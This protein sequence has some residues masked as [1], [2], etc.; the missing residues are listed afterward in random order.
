MPA[1]ANIAAMKQE[2]RALPY[3][4]N[5]ADELIDSVLALADIVSFSPPARITT[6]FHPAQY[7]YLL[8]TGTV[9]I[10]KQLAG[11]NAQQFVGGVENKWFTVGWSGFGEPH[12]YGATAECFTAC[13]ALR[14]SR[15][16]LEQLFAQFPE[17]GRHFFAL[18]L[19]SSIDLLAQARKLLAETAGHAPIARASMRMEPPH[20]MDSGPDA[21]IP[22]LRQSQ[23]FEVFDESDLNFL[24]HRSSIQHYR[25][26]SEI[27]AQHG[28]ARGMYFL[29]RGSVALWFRTAGDEHAANGPGVFLRHLTE[30]GQIL[31]WPVV[32]SPQRDDVYGIADTDTLVGFVSREAFAA[33]SERRPGFGLTFARQLL[34]LMGDQLRTSRAQLLNRQ[35]DD[36][37][38]SVGSIVAQAGPA[39]GV[40][41][42]LL[43]LPHLLQDRLTRGDAFRLLDRTRHTGTPLEKNLAGMCRDLLYETR[44]EWE[45]SRRLK[46]AYA[47]VANSPRGGNAAT[48][49]ARG[50]RALL[51]AFAQA[52]YI[53]QGEENLPAEPGHIFIL[54]HLISHPSFALPNGFELALDT[55]F[56]SAMLLYPR[57]GDG[58][59]RVVRQS[60]PREYAHQDYYDRLGYVSVVTDESDA[61]DLPRDHFAAFLNNTGNHLLAGTNVVICPEGR[62]LW[63]D[64]SPG[65]FKS[66]AF[67]LAGSL[68]PEPLIVPIAVA[69]FDKPL[70][71]TALAAIVNK[72]F[73]ISEHVNVRDQDALRNFLG[74]FRDEYRGYIKQA[75]YLAYRYNKTK[76]TAC[77]PSNQSFRSNSASRVNNLNGI[78]G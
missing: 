45:F 30:P 39:L 27:K 67:R 13:T 11:D 31:L 26:G 5:V 59:I 3:W 69:G 73:R 19:Q 15:E 48:A 71:H 34:V 49:R 62:S 61:E 2:F 58:G 22:W 24:S 53:I 43:K 55:H 56:V 17:A 68:K 60:R 7:L 36:E 18:M 9:H 63:S 76:G 12:R 8:H 40:T 70:R 29:V 50:A 74:A 46:R 25:R 10:H 66:G 44:R 47:A 16:G 20:L 21:I 54:N 4:R 14:W 23:F 64:E 41:S 38:Y 42:A 35:C 65:P 57:Y 32:D 1:N 51:D 75:Q 37:M 77:P 28:G 52:D 72:P 78:Y 6:E 33:L